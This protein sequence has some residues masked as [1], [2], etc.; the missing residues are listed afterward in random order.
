MATLTSPEATEKLETTKELAVK[1]KQNSLIIDPNSKYMKLRLLGLP[2]YLGDKKV[3][4]ASGPFG[5][6]EAWREISDGARIGEHG[7]AE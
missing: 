6:I 1:E 2:S 3:V 4:K 5:I 7:D